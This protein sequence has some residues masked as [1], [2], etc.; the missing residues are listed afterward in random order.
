MRWLH[1]RGSAATLGFGIACGA[2]L[3]LLF[4][5]SVNLSCLPPGNEREGMLPN[6][7]LRQRW[8]CQ[9]FGVVDGAAMKDVTQSRLAIVFRDWE[10]WDNRFDLTTQQLPPKG[11]AWRMQQ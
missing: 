1:L 7:R 10:E 2:L 5:T 9:W 8:Y 6:E 11:C 3:S 4:T